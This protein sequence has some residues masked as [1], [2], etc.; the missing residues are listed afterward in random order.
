MY[1]KNCWYVVADKE[2]VTDSAPFAAQ[3]AGQRIV[4][5]RNEANEIVAMD[6]KCCHRLAPLSLG[7]IEGNDIRCMYHGI[8]FGDDGR[9]NEVPGQELVPKKFCINTHAVKERYEW[10]WLWLG[11]KDDADEALIPDAFGQN[12]HIYKFKKGAISYDA[13]FE[14]FNDN[15]C[16]FS[17]VSFVHGATL[18]ADSGEM[19]ARSKPNIEF[20]ERGVRISRWMLDMPTPNGPETIDIWMSYDYLLPG[21][22]IMDTQMH[23]HGTAELLSHQKPIEITPLSHIAVTQAVTP[24]DETKTRYSYAQCVPHT[25]QDQ[26]LELNFQLAEAAFFED[27]TMLEAQQQVMLENAGDPLQTT[28]HDKAGVQFRKL[29]RE[30]ANI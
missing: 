2:D 12:P 29:V 26:V 27:K 23:P 21:V 17:H 19:L 28:S 9:C 13:N 25:E 11:S 30:A 22:L 6:D 15:L 20:L 18:G 3:V 7:R 1:P 4:L 5:Y 14:L 24:L 8:K 16:D 10:I